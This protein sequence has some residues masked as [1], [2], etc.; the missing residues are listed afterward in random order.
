MDI[1][2]G[3]QHA[4]GYSFNVLF[5]CFRFVGGENNLYVNSKNNV[6]NKHNLCI[7]NIRSTCVNLLI[8]AM[9]KNYME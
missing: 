7:V 2:L 1:A 8:Q 3:I 9:Y 6:C 4:L 5:P